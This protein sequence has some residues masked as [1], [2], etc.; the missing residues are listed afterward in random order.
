MSI[1]TTCPGC[2]SLFRLPDDLAGAQVRCQKCEKLFVVPGPLAAMAEPMVAASTAQPEAPA[3][4]APVEEPVE[5]TQAPA[6]P[7]EEVVLA[8]LAAPKPPPLPRQPPPAERPPSVV[9]ALA[10]VL[11]FMIGLF[12]IGGFATFWVAAHLAAPIRVTGATPLD[13]VHDQH[14]GIPFEKKKID[15]VIWDID[16]GW[17]KKRDFEKIKIDWDKKVDF[18]PPPPKLLPVTPRPLEF[19]AFDNRAFDNHRTEEAFGIDH[20]K[21]NQNGPYRL[22]R[23]ALKEGTTYHF[24]V[25]GQDLAPRLRIVDGADVVADRWGVEPHDRVMIAFQPKRTGDYL[26]WVTTQERIAGG[27]TLIAV[28]EIKTNPLE[29]DLTLQASYSHDGI[30]RVEDPLDPNANNFGP[31]RDYQVTLDGGREY[32]ISVSNATFPPVLRID[33]R[34]P[35]IQQP[36]NQFVRQVQQSFRPDQ[37]GKHRVRVSSEQFGIGNYTL[38]IV[39]KPMAV[40]RILAGLDDAGTFTDKREFSPSDPKQV[41]GSYK[42]YLVT[43]EEGKKYRIELSL[44]SSETTLQLLDPDDK[45]IA[46]VQTRKDATLSHTATRTGTYRVQ[47]I[48]FLPKERAAYTLR[49]STLP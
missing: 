27:F 18:F 17:E 26:L 3:P 37:K 1:T 23:I 31:Y 35:L 39:P 11:L 48:G 24:H 6:A 2:Q 44:G 46:S 30:L 13:R 16:K 21:W 28:P 4:S 19:G 43:L 33:D 8:T 5:A 29:A 22:Y 9:A 38:K 14:P 12:S 20:G 15:P 7:K 49:I 10:L 25:A 41:L 40:Q 36:P 47:A 42:E 45:T 32:L 34:N